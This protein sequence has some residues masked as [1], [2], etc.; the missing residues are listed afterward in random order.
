MDRS[1]LSDP[2]MAHLSLENISGAWNVSLS[3]A[4]KDAAGRTMLLQLS[5]PRDA[6]TLFGARMPTTGGVRE[7]KKTQLEE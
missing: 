7:L 1:I 5:L 2:A 6:V 4:W 3:H